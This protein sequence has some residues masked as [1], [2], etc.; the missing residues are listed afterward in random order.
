LGTVD[1]FIG[2]AYG[3]PAARTGQE[4]T[5]GPKWLDDDLF[6]INATSGPE[7]IPRSQ[8]DDLDMLRTLLA[9]RFKLVVRRETREVAMYALVPARRDRSR[10]PQLRPIAKDCADWIAG[11]SAT[12]PP[13][14]GD[15]P[16]GRQV[17]NRFAIRASAMT[18]SQL[19]N[20]L[21]PRVE[22]SVQ[23]RTGLTGNFYL[24]LQWKPAPG[25]EGPL[26]TGLP[27]SLPTSLFTALQEQLGLTLQSTKGLVD[28][29][30]I[31][32]VDRPTPD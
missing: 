13:P 22:R 4:I 15:L 27:D 31:D 25:T 8:V 10:G 2:C 12:A 3:I 5:G 6:E 29:L 1:W 24:D 26:D 23:D 32:R 28:V 21:T 11:R 18:M 17:V 16:C 30:V 9:D 20:L 14:M 7:S 19:A